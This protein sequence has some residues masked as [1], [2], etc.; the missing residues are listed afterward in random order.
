MVRAGLR[1]RAAG[2]KGYHIHVDLDTGKAIRPE[3]QKYLDESG[4]PI[5]FSYAPRVP[6]EAL[7]RK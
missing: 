6:D 1:S 4:Q 7:P 5:G 2:I 3:E